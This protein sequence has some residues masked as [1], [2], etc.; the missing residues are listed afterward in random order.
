MTVSYND[1]K[2]ALNDFYL[3]HQKRGHE[4]H[5][6][7]SR[8]QSN[9]Y[10]KEYI[11]TDGSIFTEVNSTNLIEDVPVSIHGLHFTVPVKFFRTEFYSTDDSKSKYFYEKLD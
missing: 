8:L 6:K 10:T 4:I 5:I 3:K 11:S 9:M 1:Y 7:T 2:K